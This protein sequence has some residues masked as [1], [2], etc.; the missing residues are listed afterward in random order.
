MHES[1]GELFQPAPPRTGSTTA[2][3]LATCTSTPMKRRGRKI[4]A[5]SIT[6]R[7]PGG[8]SAYRSPR[9]LAAS[10][11]GTGSGRRDLLFQ[12]YDGDEFVI[13]TPN[14]LV[15]VLAG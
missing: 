13:G 15:L 3:R 11:R 9:R 12:R 4:I 5:G 6:V 2:S 1:G 7:W 14:T 10:G 8:R